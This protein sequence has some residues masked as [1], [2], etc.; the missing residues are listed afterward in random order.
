MAASPIDLQAILQ[1]SGLTRDDFREPWQFYARVYVDLLWALANHFSDGQTEMTHVEYTK[2]GQGRVRSITLCMTFFEKTIAAF[3]SFLINHEELLP[4][5]LRSQFSV[6]VGFN[7][8]A[9]GAFLISSDE[10]EPITQQQYDRVPSSGSLGL[11]KPQAQERWDVF[12]DELAKS[13]E[14]ALRKESTE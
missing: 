10:I 4:K 8:D 7:Y 13:V 9:E 5:D 12:Q 2:D 11:P 14:V 1:R 6:C 3:G